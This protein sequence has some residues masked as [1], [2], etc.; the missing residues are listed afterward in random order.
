MYS[1]ARTGDFYPTRR[2]KYIGKS[3]RITYRSSWEKNALEFF[4]NNVN[5]LRWSYEDI[6]IPYLKP[7]Q[8]GN[9]KA[10]RYIPDAYV[11]YRD[12][13]GNIRKELLEIKPKKQT[14]RSKSRNVNA[15]MYENYV[16]AVNM[17]KWSAAEQWCLSRGI[18]FRVITEVSIFGA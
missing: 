15:Q 12:T 5:V 14:M 1:G 4:D 3:E 7:M 13:S 10:A 9:L 8:N 11:E 17:A 16:Y 18:K 2:E 6:I